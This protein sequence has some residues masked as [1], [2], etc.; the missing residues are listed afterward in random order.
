MRQYVKFIFIQTSSEAVDN[1]SLLF[2]V[3]IGK[4]K[5]HLQYKY[6]THDS[7]K[8]VALPTM[9]CIFFTLCVCL[10]AV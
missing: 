8:Q 4:K 5:P 10:C 7:V 2:S 1:Y 6:I 9:L 3:I